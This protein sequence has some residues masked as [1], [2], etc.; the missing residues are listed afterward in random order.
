MGRLSLEDKIFIQYSLDFIMVVKKNVA[1]FKR[2]FLQPLSPNMES[3]ITA[4]PS[5]QIR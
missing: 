4:E 5:T 2:F 3:G 1:V